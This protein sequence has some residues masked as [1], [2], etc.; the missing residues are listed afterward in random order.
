MRN[1]AETLQNL[2]KDVSKLVV[3][4]QIIQKYFFIFF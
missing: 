4:F 2:S 3:L 1:G